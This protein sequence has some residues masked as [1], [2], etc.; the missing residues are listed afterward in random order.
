MRR[1][2]QRRLVENEENDMPRVFDRTTGATLGELS[3]GELKE[4]I[5]LMRLPVADDTPYP[6]EPEA[7][8]RLE[9]SGAS[10]GL[11]FAIRQMLAG[12]ESLDLG[13]EGM[14]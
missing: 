11:L 7:V 8:A 12:R 13:W 3:D 14:D 2:R 5:A 1:W 4:L 10:A 9:E 6:I